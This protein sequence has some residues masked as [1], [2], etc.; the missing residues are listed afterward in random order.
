MNNK[1][2][3]LR[4]LVW[5]ALCVLPCLGQAD[6]ANPNEIR[7]A[8]SLD[9]Q[10]QSKGLGTGM[11]SGLEAALKD[12]QVGTKQIKLLSE[13]DNYSPPKT[14]EAVNKLL[15]QDVFA[16]VGNVGTP[17]AVAALPLLA[18]KKVPAIGFFTGAELL[19]GNQEGVINYR[20]SYSQ[21]VKSVVQEAFQNGYGPASICAYV[22]DDAY[23]LSGLKGLKDVLVGE[24]GVNFIAEALDKIFQQ[25]GDDAQRNGIGPVGF[26]KRNS[27]AV[28]DAYDSIK[29]W[30]AKQGRACRFV[31]T[32]GSYESVARFITYAQ[33][34]KESWVYSAVSFTGA[35]NLLQ[36]LSNFGV[37][38][39][40]LMT[41][42]VPPLD[43]SLPIVNDARAALGD[44]L[45]YVSLEGYIVGRMLLKAM[46][47]VSAAGKEVNREN[48]VAALRG[49]HFDLGGLP[50]DFSNDNQGS[51]LVITTAL[52]NNK[53]AP[54]DSATWK[55]W[56]K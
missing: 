4:Q 43:S 25:Q 6:S 42:V 8:T 26:Y 1:K 23:G 17:T 21:E 51:D 33:S 18:E 52:V 39:R 30:E 15:S 53:W 38:D 29:T 10:G 16:F 24:Q 34:K 5:V 37:K 20:A 47:D 27:L 56:S 55:G 36:Q 2:S 41:Q 44:K 14:V 7:L 35:D 40:V 49:Q 9:L 28:R 19:R 32:V 22:Q 46:D 54:V 45:G 31:V 12:K 48:V 50:L 3:I 11:L 13:N